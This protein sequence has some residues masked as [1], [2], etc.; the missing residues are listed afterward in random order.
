[1]Q[2]L[3]IVL[4]TIIIHLSFRVK[5]SIIDMTHVPNILSGEDKP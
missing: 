4:V 2:V 1:M 5:M 3:V